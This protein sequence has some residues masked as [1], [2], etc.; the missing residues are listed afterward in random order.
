MIAQVRRRNRSE[1]SLG[2]RRTIMA[3]LEAILILSLLALGLIAWWL[4][5]RYA[6]QSRMSD[7]RPACSN[8]FYPLGGWSSSRC[9]ECGVDVKS[10]GVRTG[11]QI[12]LHL[13]QFAVIVLAFITVGP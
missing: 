11:P 12:S 3:G 10:Q 13:L 6:H 4:I 1:R 8:C 9:P 2:F 5:A 7:H